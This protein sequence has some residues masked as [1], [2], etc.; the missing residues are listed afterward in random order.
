MYHTSSL[1]DKVG[2]TY[3]HHF[4]FADKDM[5]DLIA[6]DNTYM[7]HTSSLADRGSARKGEKSRS[8]MYKVALRQSLQTSN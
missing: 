5:H 3:R 7:Y 8:L 2:V 6:Y 1:A 4:S